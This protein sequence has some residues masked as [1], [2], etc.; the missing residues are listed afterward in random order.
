MAK[1]VEKEDEEMSDKEEWEE[2]KKMLETVV[3][4]IQ[5]I[6]LSMVKLGNAAGKSKK[7]KPDRK[8]SGSVKDSYAAALKCSGKS[9]T[10]ARDLYSLISKLGEDRGAM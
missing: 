7:T 8:S 6:L 10:L 4:R 3:Q 1:L 2:E 5:F 9:P